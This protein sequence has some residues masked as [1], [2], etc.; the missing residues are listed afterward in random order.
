MV[1]LIVTVVLRLVGY[2]SGAALAVDPARVTVFVMLL[3]PDGH[4]V[5][6]FVDDVS[7]GRESLGAVTGADA[8]P[9]S[10]FADGQ[11]TNPVYAC[12]VFDA[13]ALDGFRDDAIAF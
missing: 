11:V 12:G 2:G 10:H 6:D 3:F 5:F 8:Y 4:A 9:N 7:A 13:E 1:V